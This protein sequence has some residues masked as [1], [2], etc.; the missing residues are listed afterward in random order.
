[1]SSTTTTTVVC[2]SAVRMSEAHGDS[3][4]FFWE[5]VDAVVDGWD[6][7]LVSR[8]WSS[9][10]GRLVTVQLV[11][12]SKKLTVFSEYYYCCCIQYSSSSSSTTVVV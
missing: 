2:L 3:K 6:V 10:A 7:E 1:M 4:D 11:R 12:D 9:R 8:A 5:G